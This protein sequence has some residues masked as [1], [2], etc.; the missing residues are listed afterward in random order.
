[1]FDHWAERSACL[2]TGL[3]GYGQGCCLRAVRLQ[4]NSCPNTVPFCPKFSQGFCF[5]VP[6]KIFLDG[7][8]R[9]SEVSRT[10]F[11]G[12]SPLHGQVGGEL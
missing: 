11:T 2:T 12:V 1:M 7:F 4:H 9:F 3:P 10:F 6:G 5:F 8:G